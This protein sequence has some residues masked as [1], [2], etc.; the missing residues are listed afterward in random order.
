MQFL[1]P[2]ICDSCRSDIKEHGF[3]LIEIIMVILLVG[4]IGAAGSELIS[5]FF[6][7]FSDTDARME[8]FEEGKLAMMRLERDLHHMVPNAI[9]ITTLDATDIHFGTIDENRLPAQGLSGRFTQSSPADPDQIQ[10]EVTTS[11]LLTGDLISIYN[12]SWNDFTVIPH[13]NRRI[14]QVGSVTSNIMTLHKDVLAA[15]ATK[16]Y[17]PLDT[18]V[19]YYLDGTGTILLRSERAISHTSNFIAALDGQ[20]GYPLLTNITSLAFNYAPP[21]L[22]SNGLVTI[23]VT[24]SRDDNSVSIHKE[25]QVRNVP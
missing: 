6:R 24:L 11:S 7:G 13:A 20:Q 12:T 3:T 1:I 5:T 25:I 2:P 23:D 22:T 18:A 9:D 4:I 10:D 8:L 16:R 21:S 19:R 17:Y 14:Y 15:P